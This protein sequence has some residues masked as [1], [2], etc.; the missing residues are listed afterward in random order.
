M[1]ATHAANRRS[2][3]LIAMAG[4]PGTGKST[5]AR[6]LAEE[7]QGTILDKDHVRACLFPPDLIAYT[8][9]Q[10]DLCVELMLQVAGYLIT[11]TNHRVILL[12]GRTFSRRDQVA[13]VVAAAERLGVPLIFIECR[14]SEETALRRIASDHAELAHPAENRDSDLYRRVKAQHQ[15]LSVPHLTVETERPLETCLAEALHYLE[16]QLAWPPTDNRI[17][18]QGDTE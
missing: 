11:H 1:R 15:T 6:A 14:C 4:L 18:N 9:T 17:S 12:D 2:A 3:A 10:D 8:R 16:R 13:P 7:L 5:L